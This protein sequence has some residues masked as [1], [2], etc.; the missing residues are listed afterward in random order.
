MYV[1]VHVMLCVRVVV[2]VC[3]RCL[4]APL[5]ARPSTA[6]GHVRAQVLARRSP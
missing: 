3:V 4:V 2:V 6:A 1:R 5:R